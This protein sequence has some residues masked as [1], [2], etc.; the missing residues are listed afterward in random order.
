[1]GPLEEG[2]VTEVLW[3]SLAINSGIKN[4]ACMFIKYVL[5]FVLLGCLIGCGTSEEASGGRKS[6]EE[7]S[8]WHDEVVYSLAPAEKVV[9]APYPWEE[10]HASIHP[11]ITKDFFRCKG[12]TLN[13]PRVVQENG[14]TKRFFDCG[15]ADAHSLPLCDGKEFIY[16]I[17]ISLLN[18]VQ[19][20]TGKKV[21][22]T[23]GHRCP[24]HNAYVDQ[25]KG[26]QFSKHQIGGEVSFYVRGMEEKPDKVVA[27]LQKYYLETPKY[28]GMKEYQEFVRWEK[29]TDVTMQP[30]YNREIFIK[31]YQKNE[32]RNLDNRHPY[33]YVSVQVRFDMDAKEKV[34]YSWDK[35]F[36]NYMRW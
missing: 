25:S 36:R 33:P 34:N 29:P 22:I 30:W 24:E 1:M 6:G 19:K 2:G 4:S 16:P 3:Y 5:T 28:Q 7:I 31:L 11:K 32:G 20:H 21:V 18:E 26:N 8:R 12:S 14:E 15:G 27:L 23:S 35:A 13:A 10:E 17:L 9:V